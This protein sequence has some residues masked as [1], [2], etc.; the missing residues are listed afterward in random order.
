[1]LDETQPEG[2]AQR[3]GCFKGRCWLHRGLRPQRWWAARW[4]TLFHTRVCS[5]SVRYILVGVGWAEV[6]I[7]SV[8]RAVKHTTTVSAHY[9]LQ[10]AWL[11]SVPDKYT[12]HVSMFPDLQIKIQDFS[13]IFSPA[14]VFFFISLLWIVAT[15]Q[16]VHRWAAEKPKLKAKSVTGQQRG[17]NISCWWVSPASWW[18]E[19]YSR[20]GL[21]E[22]SSQQ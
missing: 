12:T 20:P 22:V 4:W 8:F 3:T 5:E 10:L 14:Q 16:N 18:Q 6:E 7:Q 1:M 19:I 21:I 2:K 9:K 11:Q 17:Y 15:P 13:H